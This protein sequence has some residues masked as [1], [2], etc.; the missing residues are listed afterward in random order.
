MRGSEKEVTSIETTFPCWAFF[1]DQTAAFIEEVA[2]QTGLE[3]Q[4]APAAFYVVSYRR[5][6]IIHLAFFKSHNEN[7]GEV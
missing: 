4:Y 1:S 3:L 2:D 6:T 5:R 7:N